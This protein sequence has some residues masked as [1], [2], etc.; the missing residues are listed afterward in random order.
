MGPKAQ[1]FIFNQVKKSLKMYKNTLLNVFNNTIGRL[2]KKSWYVKERIFKHREKND[3]K[4]KFMDKAVDD[5]KLDMEQK[6]SWL[7]SIGS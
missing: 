6:N 7:I 5:K 4:E 1:K 3:C 2:E